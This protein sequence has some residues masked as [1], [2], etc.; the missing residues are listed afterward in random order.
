MRPEYF[1]LLVVSLKP[2]QII[3][4]WIET[5]TVKFQAAINRMDSITVYF[6]LEAFTI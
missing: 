2:A 6:I 4:S 5:M 3:V 1:S